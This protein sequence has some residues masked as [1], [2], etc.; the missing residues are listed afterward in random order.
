MLHNP[1]HCDC[2]LHSLEDFYVHPR[3]SQGSLPWPWCQHRLLLSLP[4]EICLLSAVTIP[5]WL[6]FSSIT[7]PLLR[8]PWQQVPEIPSTAT[9]HLCP[10]LF[11]ALKIPIFGN[12]HERTALIS[13]PF[14]TV[15][16]EISKSDSHTC[17]RTLFSDVSFSL[18][19]RS[20]T[21]IHLTPQYTHKHI[22]KHTSL[23]TGIFLL[24]LAPPPPPPRLCVAY[25]NP[26][27]MRTLFFS[28]HS[29]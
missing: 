10:F 6:V 12:L 4:N 9:L 21:V 2:V 1:P 5:W 29:L 20:H 14:C 24:I 25:M 3:M 7:F 28:I 22:G 27:L 15:F 11:W 16:Y 23:R 8:V 13:A 18:C 19:S 26:S 17:A